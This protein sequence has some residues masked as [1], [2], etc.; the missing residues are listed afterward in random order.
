MKSGKEST[1]QRAAGPEKSQDRPTHTELT[2]TKE[3]EKVTTKEQQEQ[4]SSS[5]THDIDRDNFDSASGE[6]PVIDA[7][8]TPAPGL[9]GT[10]AHLATAQQLQET[11]RKVKHQATYIQDLEFQLRLQE[12]YKDNLLRVLPQ[13]Q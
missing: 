11:E 3:N 8:A 5:S 1:R 9:R 7:L 6:L 10:L 12:A 2:L 4:S 13:Y